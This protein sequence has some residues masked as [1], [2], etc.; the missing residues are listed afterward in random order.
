MTVE[1]DT[2][3]ENPPISRRVMLGMLGGSMLAG[4]VGCTADSDVQRPIPSLDTPQFRQTPEQLLE[5]D[6]QT[7]QVNLALMTY[8]YLVQDRAGE[9]G[10]EAPGLRTFSTREGWPVN[11]FTN[12]P[13]TWSFKDGIMPVGYMYISYGRNDRRVDGLEFT[14]GD[15]TVDNLNRIS[16]WVVPGDR[17]RAMLNEQYASGQPV[18][19]DLFE[20]VLSDKD[21]RYTTYLINARPL[22]NIYRGD[23]ITQSD[24]V[25]ELTGLR[26]KQR[27]VAQFETLATQR[28]RQLGLR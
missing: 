9:D 11:G 13:D 22:E 12:T 27:F 21:A 10:T 2:F 14:I 17:S 26:E 5:R 3:W 28:A 4:V 8:D 7:F 20:L 18:S 24:K 23:M 15:T 6:F 16:Q 1:H 25:N 19:P